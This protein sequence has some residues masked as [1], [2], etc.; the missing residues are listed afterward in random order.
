MKTIGKLVLG[1]V[2][3][4]LIA[5]AIGTYYILGN[6]NTLVED[7]VEKYGSEMFQAPVSVGKVD[8]SLTD[9][10]GEVSGLSLGNPRGFSNAKAFAIDKA[11]VVIDPQSL[12][13]GVV[14]INTIDI[15]GAQ[16]KMEQIGIDKNNLQT[17][18]DNLDRYSG[19]SSAAGSRQNTAGQGTTGQ[20]NT[21]Q[22]A[23]GSATEP[24]YAIKQFN[25]S[26]ADLALS[27]DLAGEKELTIPTIRLKNLGAN[28]GATPEELASQLIRPI[29][30]AAIKQARQEALDSSMEKALEHE[31]LQ[32]AKDLL[33]GLDG[34]K[35]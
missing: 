33:K 11:V 30:D 4:L 31:K 5:V 8:I 35:Q 9:G 23:A 32:E 19:S 22:N 14:V 10:K 15:Q 12:T 17:L 29:L 13:S 28:G 25:F 3:L 6:L 16:V 1:L 27:S 18:M 20:D 2:I 21:G 26:E 7:G 34:L 24:R